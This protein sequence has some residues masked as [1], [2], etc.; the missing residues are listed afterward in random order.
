[1]PQR[2]FLVLQLNGGVMSRR[3]QDRLRDQADLVRI[4]VH[5]TNAYA[6]A[7]CR[8]YQAFV[9][10]LGDEKELQKLRRLYVKGQDLYTM[11]DK[12]T[13]IPHGLLHALA[14]RGLVSLHLADV[15]VPAMD[16]RPFVELTACPQIK[17]TRVVSSL[18][19]ADAPLL[20]NANLRTLEL[21]EV[22]N[23]LTSLLIAGLRDHQQ[24]HLKVAPPCI[25]GEIGQS[26]WDA[27]SK[28][29]FR[30]HTNKSY[31]LRCIRSLTFLNSPHFED[32][33]LTL[34]DDLAASQL[35]HL[36]FC[37]ASFSYG[38]LQKLC[39]VMTKKDCS[40]RTMWFR[41]WSV[42]SS[43]TEV[44]D[45]LMFLKALS[46]SPVKEYVH[47]GI[48][49]YHGHLVASM[50]PEL[51]L[52]VAHLEILGPRPG[53]EYNS[54]Y[55]HSPGNEL[56]Q[57][58]Q[59]DK[60]LG[61]MDSDQ[62]AVAKRKGIS[63]L[64]AVGVSHSSYNSSDLD[65][66]VVGT[67]DVFT[68]DQVDALRRYEQR[69]VRREGRRRKMPEQ[70]ECDESFYFKEAGLQSYLDFSE[71]EDDEDMLEGSLSG[72]QKVKTNAAYGSWGLRLRQSQEKLSV[73]GNW[74]PAK[75]NPEETGEDTKPAAVRRMRTR[76]GGQK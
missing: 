54:P 56:V 65:I 9:D 41:H 66:K 48:T 74:T 3:D 8:G 27:I 13:D 7:I 33:D 37:D 23:I 11:R 39:G 46:R 47:E 67:W 32:T 35:R 53:C 71:S 62:Q 14:P 55:N 18:T 31:N 42:H 76:S 22:P 12:T 5:L 60:T 44:N 29:G 52:A 6:H 64:S 4:N 10:I 72:A 38:D 68:N 16:L 51:G 24:I 58:A 30:Q 49:C 73:Y 1:M 59:I 75:R 40:L 63:G 36:G 45:V 69:N 17:F 43:P 26:L 28:D 2:H 70:P 15:S 21:V 19:L 61:V 57:A 50:L 34:W 25:G 20:S